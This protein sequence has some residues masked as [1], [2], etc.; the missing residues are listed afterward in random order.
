MVTADNFA[1][2]NEAEYQT[3][4]SVFVLFFPDCGTRPLFEKKKLTDKSEKE[5]LESYIGGRVVHGDDAEQGSSP[6]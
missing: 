2:V 3:R 5:L 6:W 1:T 4:L